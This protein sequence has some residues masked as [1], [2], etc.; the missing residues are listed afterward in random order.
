MK[1]LTKLNIFNHPPFLG[2]PSGLKLITIPALEVESKPH[3][4][5]FYL[6]PQ[7]KTSVSILHEFVQKALK[8]T[9]RY[10]FSET[11]FNNT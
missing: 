3:K 4:R 6:N 1:I 2:L 5:P 10:F 11:R 8:C 9:V 7:G